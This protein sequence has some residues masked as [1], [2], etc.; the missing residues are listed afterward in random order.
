MI[1]KSLYTDELN[2]FDLIDIIL[3]KKWL[4]AAFSVLSFTVCLGYVQLT[5]VKYRVSVPYTVNAYTAENLQICDTNS[6]QYKCLQEQVSLA[7]LAE[8]DRGWVKDHSVN[9]LYLVT[10]DPLGI[11]QYEAIFTTAAENVTDGVLTNAV[12]ELALI[13]NERDNAFLGTEYFAINKLTSG[14]LVASIG[15]GQSIIDFGKPVVM[16]KSTSTIFLL[17]VSIVLGCI[18]GSFLVTMHNAYRKHKALTA[19]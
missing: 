12:A 13:N 2:L 4:I 11:A 7:L 15:A 6:Q 17:V 10:S 1:E 19:A 5:P 16:Q 3:Q 8:L 14:R 18:F 9:R